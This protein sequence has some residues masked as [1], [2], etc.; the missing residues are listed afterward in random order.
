MS[1]RRT[2]SAES[3]KPGLSVVKCIFCSALLKNRNEADGSKAVEL[4]LT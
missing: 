2:F 4:G 3:C 1:T